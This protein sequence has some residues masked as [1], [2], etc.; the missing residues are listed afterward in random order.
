MGF[1]AARLTHHFSFFNH[2]P[3]IAYVRCG[4]DSDSF[5]SCVVGNWYQSYRRCPSSDRIAGVECV[6]RF[7]LKQNE[8]FSEE[9]GILVRGIEKEV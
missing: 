7:L 3:F 8:Q 9:K 6:G 4:M 1:K 2:T 5:T